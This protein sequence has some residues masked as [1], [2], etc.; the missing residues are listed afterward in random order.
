VISASTSNSPCPSWVTN[1]PGGTSA[2]SPFSP[3]EQTFAG[4]T[5]TVCGGRRLF[6][7]QTKSYPTKLP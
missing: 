2:L 5:G 1:G 6:H 3:Q 4:L 7:H